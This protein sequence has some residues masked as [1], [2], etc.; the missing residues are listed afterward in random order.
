MQ[1]RKEVSFVCG[2]N[3]GQVY[4]YSIWEGGG[5]KVVRELLWPCMGNFCFQFSKS[6]VTSDH[7]WWSILY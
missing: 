4:L 2:K 1:K 3:M 5:I 6:S 7:Q